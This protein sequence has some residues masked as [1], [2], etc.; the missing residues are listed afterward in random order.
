[1]TTNRRR[2]LLRGALASTA[3]APATSW[4]GA[5]STESWPS[6]PIRILV[7]FAPGG[8]SDVVARLLAQKIQPLLGQPV[9][10]ENRVGAGGLVAAEAV[11][12]G[13]A[14]GTTWLLIP[15][16]HASQAAMLR[17]MPFD[18]VD[19]L[20]FV[21]TLTVYPMFVAVAPESP[22]RTLKDLVERAKA[23]PGKLSF[24]SV[25][26]GTAHHLIGEWIAAESGAD[27]VHVPYKGSA[28]AFTDVAAGRVDLMIETATAALPYVRG[29]K[30]RAIAV[31]SDAGRA[32]VPGV[33]AAAETIPGLEYESWLGVAVAPGTPAPIVDR[34]GQA[35]RTVLAQPDTVQRLDDLG[36][37]ASP[38]SPAEF[39]ARVARDIDR[40]RR[41]VA[42]RGIPQE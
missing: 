12:R 41:I 2:S 15:S 16:G 40:F 34:L 19:G 14:D 27:L 20:A 30:L 13:P 9:V 38:S 37:R 26:V 39:R 8:S 42:S 18:P 35:I 33:Q 25:G 11:A 7:G 6:R 22:I 29:G 24:T 23:A 36:G 21:G 3:L 4:V 5:Q 32:L 10:V 1:M 17:R 28:A 31:T